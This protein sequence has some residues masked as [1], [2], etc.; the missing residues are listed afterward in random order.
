MIADVF[1]L[2]S[3]QIQHGSR[4]VYAGHDKNDKTIQN[5]PW[6]VPKQSKTILGIFFFFNEIKWQK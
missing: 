6:L 2:W 3:E 4:D 5:N 1:V